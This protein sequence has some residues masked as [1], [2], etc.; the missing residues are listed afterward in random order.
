[1]ITLPMLLLV[2]YF[3]YTK[4]VAPTQRQIIGDNS[5]G[6]QAKGS[7]SVSDDNTSYE[8]V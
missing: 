4:I 3:V 5:V 8:E 1:M 2:I 6:I 7:I